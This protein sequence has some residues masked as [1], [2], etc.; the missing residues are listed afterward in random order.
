MIIKL[1]GWIWLIS[2]I[3]F[4]L[5]PGILRWQIHRKSRKI[6]KRYLFAVALLPAVFLLAI[7][8]RFDGLLPKVIMFAGLIILVKSV[9]MLKS[10][11]SGK[12]IDF[13]K[14]QPM[15]FFRLWALAQA[16]IGL[17]IVWFA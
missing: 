8:F 10:R 9:F 15:M 5:V 7:G 1:I 6:V 14:K 17:A 3:M 16:L 12:I 4:V 2:G 11:A 13:L